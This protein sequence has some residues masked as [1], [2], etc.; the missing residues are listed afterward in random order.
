V[1]D[2]LFE[3]SLNE[4]RRRFATS[5]FGT[6]AHAAVTLGFSAG[7]LLV[8]VRNLYLLAGMLL[9]RPMW[10]PFDPLAV[11]TDEEDEE[12]ELRPI[13]GARKP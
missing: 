12:E 8:N 10:N 6:T 3:N 2:P 9:T 7:Y 4:L 11:L 5:D 1:L 13:F